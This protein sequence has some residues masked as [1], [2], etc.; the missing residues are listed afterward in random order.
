MQTDYPHVQSL[1][2]TTILENC[3]TAAKIMAE[4]YANAKAA[5]ILPIIQPYTEWIRDWDF[6][7]N[8]AMNYCSEGLTTSQL[9]PTPF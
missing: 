3:I 7:W 5:D 1:P 4:E 9:Y 8:S 2:N 6:A